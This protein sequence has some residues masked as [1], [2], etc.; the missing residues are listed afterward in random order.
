MPFIEKVN[1]AACITAA[2]TNERT[3][4]HTPW[5]HLAELDVAGPVWAAAGA[6]GV[7]WICGPPDKRGEHLLE[8]QRDVPE[9]V[10]AVVQSVPVIAVAKNR[11][12]CEADLS[13]WS[14]NTLEPT[15]PPPL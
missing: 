15:Y 4:R 14:A 6:A 7:R 2:T 9:N 5:L 8:Y 1:G 3:L 13:R 12:L 11:K 10:P